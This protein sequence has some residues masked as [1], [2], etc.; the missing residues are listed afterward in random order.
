MNPY[1]IYTRQTLGLDNMVWLLMIIILILSL[2]LL[3]YKVID[4]KECVPFTF[5]VR[6]LGL[7]NDSVFYVGDI[8]SFNASIASQDID[9]DFGDN[10]GASGAYVSHVFLKEGPFLITARSN[11]LCSVVKQIIIKSPLPDTAAQSQT[12]TTGKI[13]GNTSFTINTNQKFSY[14]VQAKS[15]EW[16]V[17]NQPDFGIK[18]GQKVSFSFPYSGSYRIKVR[19][20]SSLTK[21]DYLDVEVLDETKPKP[22]IGPIPVLVPRDLTHEPLPPVNKGVV[23]STLNKPKAN[24]SLF[25]PDHLFLTYLEQVENKTMTISDFKIYGINEKTP[26]VANGGEH[27]DFKWLCDQ[28]TEKKESRKKFAGITISTKHINLESA[29][30]QR[31]NDIVSIINVSYNYKK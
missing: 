4:K 31:M 12:F 14:P 30:L 18:K 2:G 19:L 17:Q 16:S 6:N 3:S 24:K 22:K 13:I 20:D 5:K 11:S 23:D 9:W 10:N 7:H 28:L 25:I 21:M 8:L 15:Y 29:S 1:R 27:H 26:V